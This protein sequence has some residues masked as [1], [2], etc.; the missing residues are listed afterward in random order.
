MRPS[1]TLHHP[2][3]EP[4]DDTTPVID[5]GGYTHLAGATEEEE[6]YFESGEDSD[7]DPT[8]PANVN[9]RAYNPELDDRG[10]PLV[11]GTGRVRHTRLDQFAD[12]QPDSEKPESER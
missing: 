2:N 6:L 9:S 8:N 11:D 4:R 12:L 1:E 7:G 10:E 3:D 5:N